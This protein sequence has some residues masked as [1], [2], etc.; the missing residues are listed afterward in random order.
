MST[1]FLMEWIF[2]R[3][4]RIDWK[5]VRLQVIIGA[6]WLNATGEDGEK[7]LFQDDDLVRTE[8]EV[9]LGRGIPVIPVLIGKNHMPSKSE[10]PKSIGELADR[11]GI[12][13]RPDP[14]FSGDVD[15]LARAL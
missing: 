1:A 8:I 10:L 9:A 3:M 13:V 11:N 7:R 12:P 5:I 4:F 14:D 2:G 15:R 6:D